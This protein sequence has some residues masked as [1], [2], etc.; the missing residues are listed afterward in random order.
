MWVFGYGSLVW[1]PDF[2]FRTRRPAF[3]YGWRRRFWQ[4]STDH[5]GIPTAPGRV[6]TLVRGELEER[7]WGTAYQLEWASVDEVVEHLDFRERG[8]YARHEIE[9]HLA[10]PSPETVPGLVYIATEENE[11]Y[12]G[13]ASLETI[14]AQ[15]TS[16]RGP[17]GSNTEYLHELAKGLR[18]M[19]ADDAHVFALEAAVASATAVRTEVDS[20]ISMNLVP[21]A[22][23]DEGRIKALHRRAF[24]PMLSEKPG[25]A[26]QDYSF[27]NAWSA[28]GFRW[29]TV[30]DVQVGALS[31]ETNAEKLRICSL[32]VDPSYQGRGYGHRALSLLIKE[33]NLRKLPVEASIRA[34][35]ERALKFYESAGFRNIHAGA[36]RI[37]MC[38]P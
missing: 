30:G 35:N 31:S 1:R 36:E 9:I 19:G 7:C 37:R 22:P 12:A 2:P 13:P 26:W 6:A 5:R 10:P 17:S 4:S 21:A 24:R 16:A 27:A 25:L 15:I 33:A 3:I 20:E 11:N 28:S 23:S 8:G 34:A 14:A 38:R 18:G 29:I 32:I